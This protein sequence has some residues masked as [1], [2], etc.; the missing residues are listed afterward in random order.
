[1]AIRHVYGALLSLCVDTDIV[2][3]PLTLLNLWLDDGVMWIM[4]LPSLWNGL[5]Y[6]WPFYFGSWL[7]TEWDRD[8]NGWFYWAQYRV[9][10][11][12]FV[13]IWWNFPLHE[14][15]EFLSWLTLSH[16]FH[17]LHQGISS[18]LLLLLTVNE[19]G[20][21]QGTDI[22]LQFIKRLVIREHSFF[23]DEL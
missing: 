14:S 4:L 22:H 20:E 11:V 12:A 19:S 17:F 21:N 8:M 13:N 18:C 5:V 23:S 7:V 16:T 6:Q 1:M 10:R 3:V 2:H 9:Q 15:R